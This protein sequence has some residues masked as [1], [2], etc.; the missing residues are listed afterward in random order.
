MASG[1]TWAIGPMTI[2]AGG[3]STSVPQ[4]LVSIYRQQG[5]GGLYAGLGAGLARAFLANGGGMA[6]YSLLQELL[7]RREGD[8]LDARRTK[9]GALKKNEL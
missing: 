3:G 4:Q 9:E 2:Q 8:V 5:V 1:T 6:I 7:R